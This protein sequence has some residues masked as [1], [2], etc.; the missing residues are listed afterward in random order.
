MS[1]NNNIY[2]MY[3]EEFYKVEKLN[4]I[5]NNQK[6]EID[7]LKYELS[8]LNKNIENKIISET[9][10]ITKALVEENNKLKEE[11]NN[12]LKEIDRL[13]LKLISRNED[14]D[15]NYVIDKLTN[16]ISKDSTNSSIPTS[17]EIRK[18]KTGANI[19]NH[20]EKTN[21][22]NGGQQN[23][24]GKTLTKE[25]LEQKIIN[26]KIEVVEIKHYIKGNAKRRNKIKYSIGISIDPVIEKHIFIYGKNYQEK[27][28]KKYYSDVIYDDSIKTLVVMLGNY[29]CL[30][31]IKIQEFLRDLTKDIVNLSQGTIDNIYKDFCSKT[32]GTLN[33]ITIN[34]LN[35]KYT[36]TDETV[37]SENGTESYYRGY[38][39]KYNVLY[40]YHHKKGDEPIREDNILNKYYGTIISD[41]EPGIFK[42]GTSNQDCVIHIG[43]YCNEQI[44]NI[45]EIKWPEKIF[46]LLLRIERNRKILTKFGRDKFTEEEIKLIEQEYDEILN[47][48]LIENKDIS[49]K[50][51]KEKSNRLLKRLK[52]YKSSILFYIHD[53]V[54][55]Y[56][57]N[58]MERAL[59]MIKGKTKVSGGFRSTEGAIRFGNTMSII[60][61]ARLRKM[62]VFNC[63]KS[64]LEGEALFA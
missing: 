24:K 1:I 11:L 2:E 26:N 31:Y 50:Y 43:R 38:G 42:Y 57:N 56:D 41:H 55:P 35:G 45:Y 34:I 49:S 46:Q 6:L 4:K 16:Q 29:Y 15:K 47:Q 51:W 25:Q 13:K 7:T 48:G 60:K 52:K 44:Q 18:A 37:T 53:F 39:N 17:K 9:S 32:E 64:V 14:N 28:P 58:F 21:R 59:R 54:I 22:S 36:H 63:I 30:S 62:N 61:T 40:K 23:H 20:R 19:Y 27:M 8:Y 10:K 12:A 3:E 33:N 5:I